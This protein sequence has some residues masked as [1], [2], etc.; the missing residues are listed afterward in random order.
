LPSQAAISLVA[1]TWLGALGGGTTSAINCSGANFLEAVKV[2]FNA[3]GAGGISDS[4][5][6]TWHALTN[7]NDGSSR[8]A[9]INYVWNATVS[10]SQTF[11]FTG[12]APAI[13]VAC[14]SGVQSS[15][16]PFDQESQGAG[17]SPKG[18]GSIT[19]TTNGQLIIAGLCQNNIDSSVTYTIDGSYTITDQSPLVVGTSA[20]GAE[21]YL[22]QGSLGATD[23]QWTVLSGGIPSSTLMVATIASF[24]AAP[25]SSNSNTPSRGSTF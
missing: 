24:K 23:P 17:L 14:Y 5:M 2:D 19:T 25:T 18:A 6:N 8:N 3:T 13:F 7:A 21:A 16:D 12:S 20:G 10:G 9:A 1:H 4:S 22:V 15:S 11:T